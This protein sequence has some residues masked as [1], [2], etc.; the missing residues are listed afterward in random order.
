MKS[1]FSRP[2]TTLQALRRRSALMLFAAMAVALA[3]GLLAWG[4]VVL[5]PGV[6]LHAD[7]RTPGSIANVMTTLAGVVALS[8]GLWGWGAM[9]RSRWARDVQ[10]PWSYFFASASLSGLISCL[11]SLTAGNA[12]IVIAHALAASSFSL[13]LLAFLAERV[14]ARFGSR[15]VCIGAIIAASLAAG[16]WWL[17][18]SAQGAGDLRALL[19]LEILPLLLIPAGALDLRGRYTTAFDWVL[20]LCLYAITRVCDMADGPM[21]EWTGWIGGHTLTQLGTAAIAV[22]IALRCSQAGRGR[23]GFGSG[24]FG[25][26]SQRRASLNTS[27]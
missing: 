11:H 9:Q 20:M 19:L 15:P 16:T 12:A 21:L 25:D 4:P 22:W 24:S 5:S 1:I 18:A 2:A 27:F 17:D 23:H 14:D 8:A 6:L 3:A 26:S 10:R 7:T 13:V